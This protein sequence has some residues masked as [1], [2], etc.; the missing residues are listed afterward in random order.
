M[1]TPALAGLTLADDM[2]T[3]RDRDKQGDVPSRAA[4]TPVTNGSSQTGQLTGKDLA[5]AYVRPAAT[6][7]V[8]RQRNYDKAIVALERGP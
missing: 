8:G 1:L 4:W 3:C 5:I 7:L 2:E 6:T